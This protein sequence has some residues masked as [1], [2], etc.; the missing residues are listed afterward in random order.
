MSNL[1]VSQLIVFERQ[2]NEHVLLLPRPSGAP[3]MSQVG[4]I[5]GWWLVTRRGGGRSL[6][7]IGR[8]QASGRSVRVSLKRLWSVC[9]TFWG[10]SSLA[11]RHVILYEAWWLSGG[12]VMVRCRS[13]L[14]RGSSLLDCCRALTFRFHIRAIS[15]TLFSADPCSMKS[16]IAGLVFWKE[17]RRLIVGSLS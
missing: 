17:Q 1:N 16:W 12:T 3:G 8:G 13:M 10:S 9:V 7:L 11:L 15:S 5:A 2:L 14:C 6:Y 4:S